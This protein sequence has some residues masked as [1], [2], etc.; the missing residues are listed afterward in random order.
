MDIQ[1]ATET[2]AAAALAIKAAG[3]PGVIEADGRTFLVTPQGFDAKDVTRPNSLDRIPPKVIT[4]QVTIQTA[5]SLSEYVNRFKTD[6]TL[7]IGDVSHNSIKAII[8][9][10][11]PGAAA[12]AEHTATLT[13]PYS[14]EWQTWSA[15]SGKM[16]PQ[17]EFARFL[18]EN[19]GDVVAPAGA[20]LLEV[21]RDLQAVR[22]ANFKKAVRTSSDN[23]DF[24]YSV[25]TETSN[26]NGSIEIPTRFRLAIPVYFG[27]APTEMHAFLRWRLDEGELLLG[28]VLH[29][30]EH[31]RQAVFKQHVQTIADRTDRLAIFGRI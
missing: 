13:L 11:A 19:G 22:K 30:A 24:E 12:F 10:H 4:Q 20:D 2:D 7:L 17:L 9:Y 21:C 6:D 18:E 5:D 23:E 28:I 31:V 14:F 16:L 1:S 25:E 8:D 29:R 15:A 3:A 26:R 27:D